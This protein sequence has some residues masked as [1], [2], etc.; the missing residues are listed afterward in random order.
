MIQVYCTVFIFVLT[1]SNSDFQLYHVLHS[2]YLCSH[3]F[4]Q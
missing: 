3:T 2:L 1:L 4:Q